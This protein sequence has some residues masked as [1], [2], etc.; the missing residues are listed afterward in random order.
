MERVIPGLE[1]ACANVTGVIGRR[2]WALLGNQAAVT[3]DL[4]PARTALVRAGA[5]PPAFL[6][7]PEHGLEGIA[8]DMEAVGDQVDPLTGKLVRSLYGHDP[9]TLEPRPEDLLDVD[10]VLVDLPDIGTRY[11]TFAATM[12]AMMTACGRAGVELVILD[13]PNPLGGVIREGGLLQP[14]F[15]SFV[16]RLP[17]PVRHGMTLGELALLLQRER[18]PE[19]ELTVVQCR[20][21]R[22]TA[23]FDETGL[24]WVAPSPNMPTLETAILYP[25]LCLVEATNLSE[26]RGTTRPFKLI[27]APWLDGPR[28]VAQIRRSGPQG[29]AAR[30]ARFRPAFGKHAG[31]ICSGVEFCITDRQAFSP[32][33]LGVRLLGLVH[34]LHPEHF[35]WRAEAYEFV[36]AIPAVDLLT[37]DARV[38]TVVETGEDPEPLFASWREEVRRFEERLAGNMLYPE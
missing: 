6:F 1:V 24:P 10:V 13:R 25:G 15:E 21:W 34:R 7:A 35:A 20:S 28:L 29:I 2:R 12:D 14:G 32:L 3:H 17:V 23:W 11:Y 22:R 8:Q 9:S 19:L 38:R 18:Y 37:G 16:G 36:G 4:D 26:G 5:E 31:E 33:E 30:P 27:G